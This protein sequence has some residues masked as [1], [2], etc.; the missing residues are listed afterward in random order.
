VHDTATL[1]GSVGSFP[2]G[3]GTL[4]GA[5]AATVTYEFFTTL[6]CS[7]SHSDQPVTVA[8][9]GTVPDAAATA[10]LGAGNYSYQAIYNG[11][12]NYLPATGACEPLTINKATPSAATTLHNASGGAIIANGTALDNGSGVFDTA[13]I[14]T[15]ESFALTGTV[16]FQFF[17]NGTCGGTPASTQTGVAITN[18]AATSSSHL[19]LG[20]GSYSFNAQY[21]AGSDPNYLSSAVSGCEPFSV[22]APPPTPSTP[23]PSIAIVKNP[24]AQTILTGQTATFT[25]T[26]TNTGDVTLTNVTVTDQ[27][28]PDCNKTSAQIAA[29]ASMAPGAIVTYNCS[30][31]NVQASL[32]NVAVA[33]G[34]P[35]TGGSVTAQDSAPV[36]VNA[37]LP[38]PK[39]TPPKPTPPKP[40]PTKP[41]IDIVKDP[42]T[43][44]IG[45]GGTA[46][47][48]ITVTNTGDVTLTDVTVNDPHSP[49][50]NKNLGTLRVGQ[51]KSYTCTRDNVK[52][53]FENV[54][55]ASGKPPT[56]ARVQA[57]D[58][59]NIGVKAFIP[60]QHPHIAIAKDP[61]N[62]TVTTK[63]ETSP[64]ASGA[65]KTTVTYGDAH[66]TIKVTNTGDVTLHSVTV[67]DPLSTGCNKHI[68]TLAPHQSST[69]TCVRPAVTSNFT[70][71]ATATGISPKGVKVKASNPANVKVT[72][73]TTS[74]SGAKFTG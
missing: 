67:T 39:P 64:T 4:V 72:T 66:F 59:A 27:L 37:P 9:N 55:V 65:N 23:H 7:G 26:V 45:V 21:V 1:G 32:T 40:T 15:S 49:D 34:T 70:N 33:T 38:K 44:T 60:P 10:A 24:K 43:Q 50:C 28:A 41:A 14:T 19:G 25:I 35:T 61:S 22:N 5:D 17:T 53:D 8:A 54:A 31:G 12:A 73:R 18:N 20:T 13:Q 3:N 68:G 46:T 62:Q 16:T 6:N 29:L 74:S 36:T 51:S 57:N 58:H 56:G 52:A 11:N 30:L 69:Y 42:K 71:V 47:F 2:L 63:L 48:K